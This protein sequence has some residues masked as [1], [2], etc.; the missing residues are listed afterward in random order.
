MEN[1]DTM[2]E[3][4]Y[5]DASVMY[6]IARQFSESL[7]GKETKD[8]LIKLIDDEAEFIK[9][10]APLMQLDTIKDEITSR[11]PDWAMA[12]LSEKIAQ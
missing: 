8:E 2:Q 5:D 1:E 3:Y 10:Q 9:E 6:E 12:L 7:T 4:Y 11:L